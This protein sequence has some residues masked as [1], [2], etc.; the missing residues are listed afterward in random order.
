MAVDDELAT[1]KALLIGLNDWDAELERLMNG[2]LPPFETDTD[3]EY[4][5]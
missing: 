2:E 5:N 3:S 1:V 4:D